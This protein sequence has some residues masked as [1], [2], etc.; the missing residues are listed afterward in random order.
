MGE[1]RKIN[2][3]RFEDIVPAKDISDYPVFSEASPQDLRI[4][5]SYQRDLSRKSINLIEKIVRTFSWTKFKP[6][7][8][9]KDG[10]TYLCIDGQ[11]TAIAAASHPDVNKIPIMV[12]SGENVADRAKAFVAHNRDRVAMSMYQIFHGEV[13]AGDPEAMC[14]LKSVTAVGGLIPRYPP[15]GG[16]WKNGQISAITEL[17][18]ILKMRGEA[19]LK[20]VVH[21]AVKGRC[22][23]ISVTVMRSVDTVLHDEQ[24]INEVSESSMI[25]ALMLRPDFDKSAARM[26]ADKDV[27]RHTAGAM[28]LYQAASA[29]DTAHDAA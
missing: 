4:E 7:I 9:V 28:L 25:T 1:T 29:L 14:I 23:P 12:I 24:Y 20:R 11:H 27:G 8:C 17:R 10:D 16:R 2:G 13:A 3:M 5:D 15:S 22:K 26:G 6:P 18:R 21:I 19:G